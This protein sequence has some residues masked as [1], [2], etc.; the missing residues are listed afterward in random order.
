MSF[1]F[2]HSYGFCRGLPV[3]PLRLVPLPSSIMVHH[4]SVLPTPIHAPLYWL[5]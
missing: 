1:I 3:L 4:T 5:P 2:H